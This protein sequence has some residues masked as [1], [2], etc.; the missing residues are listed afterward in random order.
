MDAKVVAIK[1]EKASSKSFIYKK[2][3]ADA[4]DIDE[5][6]LELAAS[7]GCYAE[8]VSA[9]VVRVGSTRSRKFMEFDKSW[10]TNP[11]NVA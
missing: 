5:A 11:P 6:L 8:I 7:L 2:A 10:Q 1:C 4:A 9:Y 3:E